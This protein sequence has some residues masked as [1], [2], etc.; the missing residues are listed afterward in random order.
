M[1]TEQPPYSRLYIQAWTLLS[2][3]LGLVLLGMFLFGNT[4]L[5]AGHVVWSLIRWLARPI[6]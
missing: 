6:I 3:I 2:I 1:S 4:L 5:N